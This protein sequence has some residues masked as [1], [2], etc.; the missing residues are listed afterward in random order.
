MNI[1][2]AFSR[3]LLAQAHTAVKEAYP[4]INLREDAWVW[5]AGRDHWEFHGPQDYYWHGRASNAFEARYAGWMAWLKSKG[6][7]DA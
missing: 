4:A 7:G 2:L 5:K 3:A 1:D 6:V